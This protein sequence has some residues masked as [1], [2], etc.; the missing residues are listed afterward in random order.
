MVRFVEYKKTIVHLI[1]N[2][3]ASQASN[4]VTLFHVIQQTRHWVLPFTR[5]YIF[6]IV[7][8]WITQWS[9]L[10]F[11]ETNIK[12]FAFSIT[13]PFKPTLMQFVSCQSKSSSHG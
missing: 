2:H 6:L 12:M 8:S 1:K 13:E 11:R 4:C 5:P 7:I 3:E 10:N 9:M